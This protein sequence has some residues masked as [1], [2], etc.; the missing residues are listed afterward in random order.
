MQYRPYSELTDVPNVIADG[1]PRRSTVLTLSH[2]PDSTTPVALQRDLS[3]EIALAYL[4]HPEYHV[5]A[6]VVSNNHLD[7]DGFMA[8]WALCHPDQALADP[9]LVAEVARAGDFGWTEDERAARVAFA[10][11]TLRT[12][13]SSPWGPEV[14]AGSEPEQVANL[15][16]VL[17]DGFED[18]VA[19]LDSR[20]ELWADQVANMVQTED[21]LA[22]GRIGIEENPELDLA[23]VEVDPSVPV[24]EYGYCLQHSGPCHPL[25][26][27]RRTACSRVLYFR[28]DWVGLVYRFESW[29]RFVSRPVP[30]R[31]DLTD[32]AGRLTGME[33]S[34]AVWAYAWP[35]NPNPPVAWLSPQDLAPTG[36]KRE[37]IVAEVASALASPD[38][39]PVAGPRTYSA[40]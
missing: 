9:A 4:D 10:L 15:Y 25:P 30:A 19:G 20:E 37:L 16:R 39:D 29:V 31:V 2:W 40:S 5:D 3:A 28:G 8:V 32:L 6:E 35:N 38:S 24:A 1:H 11:G 36:L 21:A 18:L 34:G 26:I 27:Y 12:P 33:P 14:F 22:E 17:L 23:V 13:S 7:I